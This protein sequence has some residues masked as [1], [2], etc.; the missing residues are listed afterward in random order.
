MEWFQRGFQFL[1]KVLFGILFGGVFVM[2]ALE[3]VL[4]RRRADH[5]RR[6]G[7]AGVMA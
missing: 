4:R 7:V 3:T 6:Y 2:L 1:L 5:R